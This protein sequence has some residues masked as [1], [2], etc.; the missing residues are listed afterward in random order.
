MVTFFIQA[1]GSIM[2]GAEF[3]L[4]NFSMPTQ[5]ETDCVSLAH[6]WIIG[7]NRNG[8]DMAAYNLLTSIKVHFQIG[9]EGF[10]TK[11]TAVGVQANG[12]PTTI[13]ELRKMTEVVWEESSL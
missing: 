9:S 5:G 6:R 12:N 4:A 2:G 7:G 10:W 13:L 8:S 11:T 1:D 3:G